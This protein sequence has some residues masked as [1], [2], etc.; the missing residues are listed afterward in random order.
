MSRVPAPERDAP[1]DHCEVLRVWSFLRRLFASSRNPAIDDPDFGSIE[2]YAPKERG[3]CGI[4]Q[5]QGD[6]DIP[7][8]FA[9]V[10]CSSIPGDSRGPFAV[11]RA[12]LLSKRD[13]LLDVWDK[14]S[15]ALEEIRA[16]WRPDTA[17]RPLKEVFV[18][19]SLALEEPITD[20]PVW[21][22]SFEPRDG[23]WIFASVCFEGDAVI[24]TSC[25][26]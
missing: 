14:A 10:S 9:R 25:D 3:P 4:W 12:F 8:A 24:A 7:S 1:S 19:T 5:M 18:L 16:Q 23:A 20:P 11:A 22:V 21:E 17:G 15:P 26:D 6:W 2:F 13:A